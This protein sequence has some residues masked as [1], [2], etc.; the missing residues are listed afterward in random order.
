M[1]I[2]G[3]NVK[4]LNKIVEDLRALD[5]WAERHSYSIRIMHGKFFVA[6][7]HLYPG[8]NEAVLKLYGDREVNSYVKEQVE[9]IIRKHLPDHKVKVMISNRADLGG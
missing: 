9:L 5:L 4:T 1:Y 2:K 6:S 8:F 3:I 7:L